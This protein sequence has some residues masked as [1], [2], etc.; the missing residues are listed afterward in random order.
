M[1]QRKSAK[2]FAKA[3]RQTQIASLESRFTQLLQL[4][5]VQ[6]QIEFPGRNAISIPSGQQRCITKLRV[7]PA[8]FRGPGIVEDNEATALNEGLVGREDQE[9]SRISGETDE[10]GIGTSSKP[11][12]PL[13]PKYKYVSSLISVRVSSWNVAWCIPFTV[14]IVAGQS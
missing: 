7:D 1:L 9:D 10:D 8:L 14:P 6:G 4:D 13:N 5:F 3:Y 12:K 2:I 11:R